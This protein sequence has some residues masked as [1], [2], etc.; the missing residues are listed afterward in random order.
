MFYVI[1]KVTNFQQGTQKICTVCQKMTNRKN[2]L[3]S[4]DIRHLI[5]VANAFSLPTKVGLSLI[6][7]N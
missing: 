2:R 4:S 3:K 6:E 1:L 7:S 5:N